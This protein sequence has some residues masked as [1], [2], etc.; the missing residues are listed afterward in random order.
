MSYRV[1]WA[2]VQGVHGRK[3]LKRRRDEGKTVLL[4]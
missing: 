1:R 3:V 4:V 2:E